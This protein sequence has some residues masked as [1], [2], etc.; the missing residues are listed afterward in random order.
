MN[1]TNKKPQKFL[2]VQLKNKKF[3]RSRSAGLVGGS[4]EAI[5]RRRRKKRD[6]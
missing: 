3:R 1:P 4:I 2:L 6:K 5:R